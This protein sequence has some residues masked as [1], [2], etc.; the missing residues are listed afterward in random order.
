MIIFSLLP[1]VC[2]A[3]PVPDGRLRHH[4]QDRRMHATNRRNAK[5]ADGPRAESLGSSDRP[6]RRVENQEAGLSLLPYSVSRKTALNCYVPNVRRFLEFARDLD[7]PM[8]S[9][10]AIDNSILIY[11]DH[12]VEDEEV[13]PHRGDYVVHGMAY[14]WPEL[15]TSLPRS[16]RALRAWHKMHVAGEGG[17]QPLEVWA[18]LDETMRL[19]GAVE[20]ADAAALAVDAYLRSAELF[21]LR[22]EDI[23][24]SNEGVV[25][26]KLGV[27]ERNERTKTG[28]RQG[29]IIDRPHVAAMLRA[30]KA[31]RKPNE[32]V[33]DCSVEAYRRALRKASEDIGVSA[34]PA[35]AA[36]HSGPSHDAAE[37]YRTVWAIQRRGRWASEKSVLRYMKTHALLAARATVPESVMARGRDIMASRAQR[38]DKARE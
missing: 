17:P 10:E 16:N 11:L 13:G 23:V 20:A 28:V 26:I 7:L 18:V 34:F 14:V 5:E 21:G 29:V 31:G 6:P 4:L 1:R 35:H 32:L 38:P 12:L 33:F 8:L 37:G 19:A 24:D 15:S 36:R 22:A 25:A 2:H 30:R 9:R 3:M 27:Q